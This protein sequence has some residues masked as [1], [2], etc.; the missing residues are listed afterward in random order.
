MK[1]SVRGFGSYTEESIEYG[2]NNLIDML[3]DAEI[4]EILEISVVEM[5]DDEYEKLSE[6]TGW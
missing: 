2:C 4:G 5:T 1:V 3:N 6:L